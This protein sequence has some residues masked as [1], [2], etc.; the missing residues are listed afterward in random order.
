MIMH[1]CP[2]CGEKKSEVFDELCDDCSKE[3]DRKVASA[4]AVLITKL[5]LNGTPT[6]YHKPLID[7]ATWHI[8][9]SMWNVTHTEDG[10]RLLDKILEETWDEL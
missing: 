3:L 1:R 7:Y 10:K 5:K 9:Q 6:M 4:I 2:L 8:K